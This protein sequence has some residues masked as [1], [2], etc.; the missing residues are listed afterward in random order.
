MIKEDL[1]LVKLFSE[2]GADMNQKDL[3]DRTPVFFAV[4]A[5]NYNITRILLLNKAQPWSSDAYNLLEMAKSSELYLMIKSAKRL[6][7]I[8]DMAPRHV[9]GQIWE[10][11]SGILLAKR[12]DGDQ[13]LD[14]R[15][16]SRV[17]LVPKKSFS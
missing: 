16:R 13:K 11:H 7:L 2:L 9:R 6:H 3:L 1:A 15:K 17:S 5:Q 12:Y 10:T 14:I 8:M 4:Q